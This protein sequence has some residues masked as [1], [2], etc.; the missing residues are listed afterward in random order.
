MKRMIRMV[1]VCAIVSA[2]SV[3]L[4]GCDGGGSEWTRVLKGPNG[5]GRVPSGNVNGGQFMHLNK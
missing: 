5:T 3:V 4:S 1:L 2:L